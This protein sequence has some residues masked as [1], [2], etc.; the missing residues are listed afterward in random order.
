M[1]Q[2]INVGS[3]VL[4]ISPKNQGHV[5]VSTNGGRS[6][7][8]RYLG[9]SAG[10]FLDLLLFGTEILAVTSKGV[11]VS[12]NGGRS[13]SSRYTGS[14]YGTFVALSDIGGKL[15][16]H[17]SKGLYASTNGGRSWSKK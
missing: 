7:S 8:S 17:T 10:T 13:W 3:E 5:E 6:W 4:R 15:M 16:A 12:T 14:S 2:M 11:Y 9:T 1:G